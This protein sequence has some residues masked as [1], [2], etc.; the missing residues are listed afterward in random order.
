MPW[1]PEVQALEVVMIRPGDA[2][3]YPE[4]D[5]RGMAHHFDVGGGIDALGAF[6]V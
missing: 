6:L 3:K 4:I 2:E 1:L 5:R